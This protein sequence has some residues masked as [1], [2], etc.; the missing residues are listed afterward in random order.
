MI[1]YGIFYSQIRN[2]S[3][4][5]KMLF[6][7]Y[8]L[9]ILAFIFC[10][11]GPR[12]IL[13][14]D[15]AKNKNRSRILEKDFFTESKKIMSHR[16]DRNFFV[17]VEPV[18]S[19][20]VYINIH[21]F[22]GSDMMTSKFLSYNTITG[23]SD[24]PYQNSKFKKIN[25]LDVLSSLEGLEN[26]WYLFAIKKNNN[27]SLLG[28]NY[29]SYKWSSIRFKEIK[30]SVL[31]LAAD[32]YDKFDRILPRKEM[33]PGDK[34]KFSFIRNGGVGIIQPPHNKT[35]K[36]EAIFLAVPYSKRDITKIYN[37]LKEAWADEIKKKN[38]KLSQGDKLIFIEIDSPP[39]DRVAIMYI[40]NKKLSYFVNIRIDGK[41][42]N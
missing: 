3:L 18:K 16:W 2:I 4:K 41:E 36:I 22:F 8:T 23:D 31:I 32:H 13:L 25:A 7:I 26:S 42:L 10:L 34:G 9:L 5:L 17:L 39:S 19:A 6:S 29:Q 30:S 40:F 11:A 24:N 35:K 27:N 37:S 38:V 28:K 1:P 14:L 33:K 20:D 12:F 21:P 15:L